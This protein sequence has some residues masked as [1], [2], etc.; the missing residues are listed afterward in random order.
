MNLNDAFV[1]LLGVEGGFTDDPKD[2]GNWTGGEFGV[3]HLEGTKYGIS[4]AAYPLE[5]IRGLTLARAMDLYRHDYWGPAGCD[6]LPDAIKYAVFD[7]AVNSGVLQA[8]KTLQATVGADA[9]GVVGPKT[10]LAVNATPVQRLAARF[11]A[12]RLIFMLGL[13]GWAY[14]SKSWARRVAGIL[15]EV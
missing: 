15:L 4:A 14:F 12:Q 5:D 3:G 1:R 7:M 2:K 9:D 8:V 10:L 11:N 6:V 13:P